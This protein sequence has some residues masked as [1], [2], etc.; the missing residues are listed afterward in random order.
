MQHF[1]SSVNTCQVDVCPPAVVLVIILL[2]NFISWKNI[3]QRH[4]FFF[5]VIQ[6]SLRG[7][8]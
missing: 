3:E 1:A 6:V 4:L 5:Y 2:L 7:L 8:I